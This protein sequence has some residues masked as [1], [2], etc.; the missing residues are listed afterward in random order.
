VL[1]ARTQVLQNQNF[2]HNKE[3]KK[4]SKILTGT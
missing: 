4:F 2:L 1:S 3:G